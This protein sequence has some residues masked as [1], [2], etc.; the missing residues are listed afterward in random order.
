VTLDYT[1]SDFQTDQEV[2]WCPGC[3][4]YTILA[5]VQQ[6]LAGLGRPREQ[7]VFV[8]GIGCAARF[9]YYVNTFGMH[10]IHGRAPAIA[11]GIA[12][13]RPDLSVW[14]ITGDGDALSIGGNHLIHSLRRNVNLKILMFNNQIYGLTKGQYSPTSEVGKRTKSSPFGSIDYPFNPVSLALGAEASFVARTLDMDRNHTQTVLQKAYDHEGSSFVEIYQNCNVFNDKAFIQIT[15]KD[16]RVHNRIDLE[17]G[18]PVV[19]DGGSK[20][21]VMREG[22]ATIVESSSVDP[23]A[24]LVHDETRPDPSVAFSLSRL[25]H[26]PFGPTPLGV[27]RNVDRPTYDGEVQRQVDDAIEKSGP[28]D[29]EKLIRSMGTWTVTESD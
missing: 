15:G 9:P 27:F 2:R 6:F 19:F 24:I 22:Q 10:S 14:V 17:H 25:S 18:K 8:S 16:E 7:F 3:G 20:A 1:R 26:G 5:S 28:G 29:L 11:S 21:V 12:A 13:T 4:D 23:K